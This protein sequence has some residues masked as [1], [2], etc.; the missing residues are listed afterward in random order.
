[1][2]MPAI[3]SRYGTGLKRQTAW[4]QSIAL[5]EKRREMAQRFL[6]DSLAL[7][8]AINTTWS[9][10]ISGRAELAAKAAANRVTAEARAKM[11]EASTIDI[12][13]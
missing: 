12:T 11:A 8:T 5:R 13:L 6:N 10:Q 4:Q 2:Q 9:N 3:K 1:M 7:G